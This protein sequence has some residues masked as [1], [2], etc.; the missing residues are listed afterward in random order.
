[1]SLLQQ[2]HHREDLARCAISTLESVVLNEGCLDRMQEATLRESLDCGDVSAVVHQRKREARVDPSAV[3]QD[4]ARATFA[5]V[6]ALLGARQAELILQR[7]EQGGA[8]V[9]SAG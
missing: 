8:R 1:M 6:A 4:G 7:V 2:S 5:T 3:D 9:N